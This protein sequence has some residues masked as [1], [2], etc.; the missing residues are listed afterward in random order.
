MDHVHAAGLGL[1]LQ[2]SNSTTT[3]TPP[4][5]DNEPTSETLAP[6]HL[7]ED[8][9]KKLSVWQYYLVS[10]APIKP[11]DSSLGSITGGDPARFV[12][13]AAAYVII[14]LEKRYHNFRKT[15]SESQTESV[16]SSCHHSRA[17]NSASLLLG[18]AE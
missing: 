6:V 12:T 4:A 15:W 10:E 7:K 17:N 18:G 1:G 3:T 13:G 14:T 16:E 9:L 5:A 8:F 11:S 2:R